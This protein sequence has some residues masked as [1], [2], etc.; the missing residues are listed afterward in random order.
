V[1]RHTDV[2]QPQTE[3]SLY[4]AFRRGCVAIGIAPR[5]PHAIRNTF[6]QRSAGR[7]E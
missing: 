5:T 7:A 1:P 6:E 2:T 4:K 3:G